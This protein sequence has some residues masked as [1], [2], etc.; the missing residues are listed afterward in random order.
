LA[1]GAVRANSRAVDFPI[2]E[3]APVMRMVLPSRRLAAA[4]DMLRVKMLC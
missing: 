2:P 4:E 1:L 3:E